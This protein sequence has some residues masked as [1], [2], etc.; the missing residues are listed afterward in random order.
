[1]AAGV[2]GNAR[3]IGVG[4]L[5]VKI[6][7]LAQKHDIPT[8]ENRA[9]AQTLYKNVDVGTSIPVILHKAVAEI[10]ACIYKTRNKWRG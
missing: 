3:D 2:S 6:E 5:A 1:V 8:V 9:L 10:L 4:F 7:E